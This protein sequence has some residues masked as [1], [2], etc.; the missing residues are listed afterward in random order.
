MN[1]NFDKNWFYNLPGKNPVPW[2]SI[3][4]TKDST[5]IDLVSKIMI[6]SPIRRL[7]SK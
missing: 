2:K 3:L 7:T 6:Y 1:N 4:K 5:L